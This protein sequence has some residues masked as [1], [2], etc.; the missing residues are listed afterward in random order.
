MDP[1]R[2]GIYGCRSPYSSAPRPSQ[3]RARRPLGL[4]RPVVRNWP[5]APDDEIGWGCR[6][7]AASGQ[8]PHIRRC[9]SGQS[10]IPTSTM[11]VCWV[12]CYSSVFVVNISLSIAL[13]ISFSGICCLDIC[14]SNLICLE[15]RSVTNLYRHRILIKSR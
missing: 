15:N 1:D 9:C 10:P 8:H 5:R 4:Y 6:F 14:L 13:S 7:S 11:T 2:V 12:H 3:R